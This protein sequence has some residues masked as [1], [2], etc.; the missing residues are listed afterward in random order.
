[1]S[2]AVLKRKTKETNKTKKGTFSL[3]GTQRNLS[4]VG[5]NYAG[6]TRNSYCFTNSKT[7]KKSV[8]N[9]STVI[10]NRTEFRKK[11]IDIEA[12]LAETINIY[13]E[14]V[15]QVEPY[16]NFYTDEAGTIPLSP[17]NTLY[18]N[19]TYVF[20]R[21][22]DGHAFYLSSNIEPTD[23]FPVDD[24]GTENITIDGTSIG[25]TGS[26]F[27]LTFSSNATPE[28]TTLYYYCVAHP[29]PMNDVFTLVEGCANL[30][31]P[32]TIQTVCNNWV[33]RVEP[34]GNVS[35]AEYIKNKRILA[36]T[37]LDTSEKQSGTVR[38]DSDGKPCV[39]TY[40]DTSKETMKSSDYNSVAISKRA[41][42]CRGWQKPFPYIVSVADAAKCAKR[43]SQA[44][45]VL[46]TYYKGAC[47][48]TTGCS[49]IV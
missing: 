4:Y 44:N 8:G 1:M 43:Y 7:I 35:Q 22:N 29:N 38:C 42:I 21:I 49:D 47:D 45:E 13:V 40:V 12:E 27:T 31:R 20:T 32:G 11:D 26:S 2:L 41:T 24:A 3:N 33:Q 36:T 18:L 17:E 16:Y 39:S 15:G 25:S 48:G 30:P 5:R 34:D 23:S 14:T 37:T 6:M 10:R 28:N 9:Q 46:D 19:N